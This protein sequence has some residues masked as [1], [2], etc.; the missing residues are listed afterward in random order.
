MWSD[1]DEI[2]NWVV[3]PHVAGESSTMPT[4]F[5]SSHAHINS[6]SRACLTS[7]FPPCGRCQITVTVV[8]TWLRFS[9]FGRTSAMW[10]RN[11]H[12]GFF[13]QKGTVFRL[14]PHTT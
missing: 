14:D 2:E 4:P 11:G 8:G 6:C 7:R 13:S 3:S 5:H 1:P 12:V 9:Q 10:P